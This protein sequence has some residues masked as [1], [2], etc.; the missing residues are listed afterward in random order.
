MVMSLYWLPQVQHALLR[1]THCPL[2]PGILLHSLTLDDL[3]GMTKHYDEEY[4]HATTSD[5]LESIPAHAKWVFVGAWQE[6]AP[7]I[8]VGAFGSR[9]EVLT[10]TKPNT[11]HWHN[12]VWW[13]LTE[14]QSFGF[15]PT[16][17]IG[18]KGWLVDAGHADDP[19][20]LS[21]GLHGLGG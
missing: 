16:D 21:W 7:T 6:G 3:D 18:K 8:A 19:A 1:C 11:P 12:G 15:A 10:R 20:R 2:Q 13:Y 14:G 4:G 9:E 17:S 5:V